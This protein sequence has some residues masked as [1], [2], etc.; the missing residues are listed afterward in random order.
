[1]DQEEVEPNLYSRNLDLTRHPGAV[2]S[3]LWAVLGK[4]VLRPATA[5]LVPVAFLPMARVCV[6]MASQA[7]AA[8][9]A[10]VRMASMVSA[11]RSPAPATRITVS[12]GQNTVKGA[13]FLF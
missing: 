5:P 2:K 4:T 7:T 8:M 1:M 12:G 13:R 6:N 11:A 10:S 9:S 3:A